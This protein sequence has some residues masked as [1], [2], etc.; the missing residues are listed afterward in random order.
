M[1]LRFNRRF[2]D[3]KEHRYWNI[4]TGGATIFAAKPTGSQQRLCNRKINV[5]IVDRPPYSCPIY[6]DAATVFVSSN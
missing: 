2:K 1:F 6:G 3:R 4:A 5:I